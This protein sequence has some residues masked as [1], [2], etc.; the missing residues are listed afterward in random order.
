MGTQTATPT[1]VLS[2]RDYRPPIPPRPPAPIRS[3]TTPAPVHHRPRTSPSVPNTYLTST[4]PTPGPQQKTPPERGIRH[5][6]GDQRAI[7]R[8]ANRISSREQ[9]RSIAQRRARAPRVGSGAGA[10]AVVGGRSRSLGAR[11]FPSGC[12]TSVAVANSL[13]FQLPPVE[14]CMRFSRTRLTDVVHRR[15]SV[16]PARPGRAWVRQ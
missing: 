6:P 3:C 8:P 13:R 10:V 4:T 15:H 7:R 12:P 11:G 9:T 14:P 5:H 1:A 2:R 16:S